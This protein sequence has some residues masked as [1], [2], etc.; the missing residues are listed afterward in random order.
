MLSAYKLIVVLLI[1][2][3]A[4]Y[5]P[6]RTSQ[7]LQNGLETQKVTFCIARCRKLCQ[8][9]PTFVVGWFFFLQADTIKLFT[10]VV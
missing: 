10:A 9:C 2:V 7:K 8:I 4:T 1:V 3:A 5:L 6:F